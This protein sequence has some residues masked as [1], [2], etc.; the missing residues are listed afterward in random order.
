MTRG[1][2]PLLHHDEIFGPDVAGALSSVS[3][4]AARFALSAV[5]VGIDAG[6]SRT[7]VESDGAA[8]WLPAADDAAVVMLAS[9]D[10]PAALRLFGR[11]CPE[12]A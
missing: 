7:I 9:H 1:G 11:L 8:A 6:P 3:I 10:R 5:F 2:R 12:F 4:G